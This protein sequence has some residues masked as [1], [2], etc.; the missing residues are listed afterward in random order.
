MAM[1][2]GRRIS[3]FT[4]T[5]AILLVISLGFGGYYFKQYRDLKNVSAKTPEEKN[6]ELVA[7]INK[8]YELP[9]DEDPVVA[10]VSDE[11]K[12][13]SEYPV[14]T[15]AKKDDSLLLYEKAGQAILFRESENRVIGTATFAVKKGSAVHIIGSVESQNSTE[16]LL[17]QKLANDV[18]ISGKSTPLATYT[19][20]TV[21]DLTGQKPDVAKKIAE[22]LGGTVVSSLPA[23][24]KASDGAEIAV[25]IGT[26]VQATTPET[27][28]P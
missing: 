14:F 2:S 15:A 21:I 16:A 27:P 13:K 22:A 6:K 12:F 23:G 17:T 4:L 18:R 3:V 26:P 1:K 11:E 19:A 25:V 5:L 28:A 9:K 20:T 7:K 8:V 10:V 24:E